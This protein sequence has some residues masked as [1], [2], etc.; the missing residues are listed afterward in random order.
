M[1]SSE[2]GSTFEKSSGVFFFESK[3][4][5]SCLSEFGKSKMDSPYFSFIFKPVFADEL[6]FVVNSFLFVRPS[7]GLEGG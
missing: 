7:G 2:K 6:E 5:T 3:E 1:H 4:L